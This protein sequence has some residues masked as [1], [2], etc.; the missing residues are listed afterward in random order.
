M[1]VCTYACMNVCM[2][3]CMNVCMYAF[4]YVRMYV[5]MYV[6]MMYVCIYEGISHVQTKPISTYS[7]VNFLI[8]DFHIT[9]LDE[10][11]SMISWPLTQIMGVSENTL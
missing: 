6:C 7:S 9:I 2:Y 3:A 4:T 8:F 10:E 1:H 11:F 5:C